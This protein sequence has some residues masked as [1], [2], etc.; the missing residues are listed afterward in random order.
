MQKFVGI[1]L[2]FE[3]WINTKL[4]SWCMDPAG[5]FFHECRRKC[6]L[7]ISGCGKY[8]VNSMDH[9][10]I[11]RYQC[12]SQVRPWTWSDKTLNC[13][14]VLIARHV[15]VHVFCVFVCVFN[16]FDIYVIMLI[17]FLPA[18]LIKIWDWSVRE[19]WNYTGV[20]KTGN[21]ILCLIFGSFQLAS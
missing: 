6:K 17:F 1:H 4:I 15:T 10:T 3:L 5:L 13:C 8:H 16:A 9:S 21:E 18:T 12:T 2:E 11:W 19:P 20:A 7:T 14:K